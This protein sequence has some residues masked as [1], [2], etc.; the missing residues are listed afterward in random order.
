MIKYHKLPEQILDLLPRAE[1]Y[2]RKNPK[3][4]FAY[5]FGGLTKGKPLPLSDVDIAVYLS[6]NTEYN[7]EKLEILGKLTQILKTDE[8]DLVILNKAPLPLKARIIKNKRILA[9]KDR[10]LR[11]RFESLTLRQYFDF[12]QKEMSIFKRRYGVGR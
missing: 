1:A 2:L 11:H 6:D 8:I 10:F 5:L 4:I 7:E 3:V 12:S 9:D